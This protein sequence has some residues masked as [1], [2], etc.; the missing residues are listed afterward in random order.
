MMNLL[1]LIFKISSQKPSVHDYV[2]K[3]DLAWHHE[4]DGQVMSLVPRILHE[5]I[6]HKGGASVLRDSMKSVK[7]P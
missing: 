2:S 3:N 7:V 4:P 1:K 5:S 6:K